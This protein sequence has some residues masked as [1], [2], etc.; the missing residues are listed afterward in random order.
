M[1]A[2]IGIAG[3]GA[4]VQGRFTPPAISVYPGAAK[5]PALPGFSGLFGVVFPGFT[6]LEERILRLTWIQ[7]MQSVS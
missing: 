6:R 7:H 4:V 3:C 5:D 2:V 1:L